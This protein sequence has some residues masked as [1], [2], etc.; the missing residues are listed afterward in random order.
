MKKRLKINMKTVFVLLLILGLISITNLVR[1]GSNANSQTVTPVIVNNHEQNNTSDFTIC[2]DAGH[3]GYDV[4]AI[5]SSNVFEKDV[6]L[7]IAL[8]VGALL[9][10]DGIKVLYTRTTDNVSWPSDNKL[11]LRARVKVS[12][13]AKADVFVSIHSNSSTESSYHGVETWCRF[14]NSSGET[15]A[16]S[17]QNELGKSNYTADRGLRYESPGHSLPVLKLNNSVSALVEIGFLS[18]SSDA[19]FITSENGQ[20][21]CANSIVKGI[22]NYKFKTQKI[23]EEAKEAKDLSI[24]A[25]KVAATYDIQKVSDISSGRG[26]K[27]GKKIAFLTFDD[28][29]STTVTPK[30]LDVLKSNNVKATFF[31]VGRYIESKNSS[32]E[33][34]KRIFREGH[35]IGNHSYSH[36]MRKL[37]PHNK[38]NVSTYM[39][40]LEK[41]NNILKGI[42]GQDFNARAIRM[43][44]GY[45]SRVYYNDPNLIEL[46]AKLKEKY[47][48]SI[49]WNASVFDAESKK[50]TAPELVEAFKHDVGTQEKI[51][52]LMHDTYGKENTAKALPEIIDYL[53]TNGYEF[54]IIK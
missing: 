13:E 25:A 44:G 21:V 54:G 42:L 29:P 1:K 41:T 43:P 38:L 27:D 40:E 5:N 17:I 31:T 39:G 19:N 47:L 30:V 49:D 26:V 14:P 20:D 4:G 2:I 34:I 53:K 22:L 23:K 18:N 15:L 11:D 8:K 51:V 37:Y 9:E 10:K 50:R 52:V 7:K 45:N 46:N 16:K 12:N 6:T 35:A 48:Y 24:K 36:D 33:L 32:R 28:G 3:G